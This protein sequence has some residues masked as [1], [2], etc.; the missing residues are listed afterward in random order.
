MTVLMAE[1]ALE[2]ATKAHEGQIDKAGQ[3]YIFHP[4]SVVKAV[5]ESLNEYTVS[6]E[7]MDVIKCA[8]YLHDVIEDTKYTLDDLRIMGFNDTVIKALDVLTKRSYETYEMYI[9]RLVLSSNP[10][11]RLIK[12]EDL[13]QNINL[14]RLTGIDEDDVDRTMKYVEVLKFLIVCEKSAAGRGSQGEYWLRR[15]LKESTD[16][17]L[18]GILG[19][20]AESIR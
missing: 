6:E 1:K 19:K 16:L 10:V 5:E 18:K 9:L 8:G 3:P 4:M 13:K 12:I 17:Y 15:N 14:T 20:L 11:A 7:D 2:L